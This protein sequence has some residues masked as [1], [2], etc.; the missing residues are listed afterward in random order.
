MD[1]TLGPWVNRGM[2][3]PQIVDEKGALR[4]NAVA[5]WDKLCFQSFLLKRLLSTCTLGECSAE[6]VGGR[7][8]TRW[9]VVVGNEFTGPPVRLLGGW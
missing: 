6:A 9:F 7:G 5:R 2:R 1:G 3:V 4:H 8:I